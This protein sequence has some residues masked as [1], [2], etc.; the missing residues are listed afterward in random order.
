MSLLHEQ[1]AVAHATL[2]QTHAHA[3]THRHEHMHALTQAS[4]MW[5]LW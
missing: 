2:A 1:A 3:R 5:A 4:D